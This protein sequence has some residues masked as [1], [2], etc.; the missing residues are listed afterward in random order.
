MG[1]YDTCRPG[2][3][4]KCGQAPGGIVNGICV[5]CG[6][7][8]DE[9]PPPQTII[10]KRTFR[11]FLQAAKPKLSPEPDIMDI[12]LDRDPAPISQKCAFC[13]QGASTG[14]T[15]YRLNLRAQRLWVCKDHMRPANRSRLLK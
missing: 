13:H 15:L 6:T 1:H 4:K 11:D 2:Y 5:S 14:H 9:S 3:C 8:S 7:T 12:L 10:G